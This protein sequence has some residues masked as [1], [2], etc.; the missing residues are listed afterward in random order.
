MARLTAEISVLLDGFV[1]G[2]NQTREEPLGEGGEQLHEWAVGHNLDS[3]LLEESVARLAFTTPCSC[4]PTS[5]A[6]RS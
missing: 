2:P 6:S 1:A 4:S 3:E 5:R